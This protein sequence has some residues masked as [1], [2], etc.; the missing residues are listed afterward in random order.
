MKLDLNMLGDCLSQYLYI[1]GLA[2]PFS[3]AL[4][5]LLELLSYGIFKVMG[6]LDIKKY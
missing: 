1:M 3:L 4:G 2:L 6:L 5:A